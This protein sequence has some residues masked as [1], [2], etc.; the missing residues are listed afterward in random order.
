M[1]VHLLEFDEVTAYNQIAEKDVLLIKREDRTLGYLRDGK[2]SVILAEDEEGRFPFHTHEEQYLTQDQIDELIALSLSNFQAELSSG[3][4]S[5]QVLSLLGGYSTLGHS[6][7]LLKRF[8]TASQAIGGQRG[9]ATNIN[10]KLIVANSSDTAQMGRFIGITR[11]AVDA[12]AS[13][14]VVNSGTFE[15][16]SFSFTP[17]VRLFYNG[18]GVLSENPPLFG[19]TQCIGHSLTDKIIF[20][21]IETPT[22]LA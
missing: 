7:E 18:M 13:V 10:G 14:E 1:V 2:V 17:N 8:Y 21:N 6:H 9:V 20:I 15:D 12:E 19:F 5:A 3:L 11:N 22:Q 4:T 16:L